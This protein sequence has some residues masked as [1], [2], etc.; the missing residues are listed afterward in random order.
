MKANVLLSLAT[1]AF[2]WIVDFKEE[3]I[4]IPRSSLHYHP[5]LRVGLMQIHQYA[6]VGFLTHL[7]VYHSFLPNHAPQRGQPGCTHSARY[8]PIYVSSAKRRQRW[9]T[10]PEKSFND[11]RNS[12]WPITEPWRTPL[13]ADIL[14]GQRWL[15]FH[16]MIYA[17][18]KETCPCDDFWVHSQR[19]QLC[20]GG[21]FDFSV[22]VERKT[23]QCVYPFVILTIKMRSTQ[24]S[25]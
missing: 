5:R 10:T 7:W 19:L 15:L 17:R 3:P 23:D 13:G 2:T 1:S 18:Q 9:L 14:I 21:L 20:T 11:T 25:L 4:M 6:S 16:S 8:F 12:R 24:I 22:F